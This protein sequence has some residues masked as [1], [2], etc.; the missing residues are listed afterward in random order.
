MCIVVCEWSV[1]DFLFADFRPY[2]NNAE[3]Y[4][5]YFNNGRSSFGKETIYDPTIYL[6]SIYKNGIRNTDHL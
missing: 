6:Q 5:N 3:S 4:N 1:G 2:L